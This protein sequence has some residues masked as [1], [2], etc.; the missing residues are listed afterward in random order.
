MLNVLGAFVRTIV[1]FVLIAVSVSLLVGLA[2]VP[3]HGSAAYIAGYL[4]TAL[5]LPLIFGFVGYR[6]MRRGISS[7]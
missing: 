6:M 7:H 5:L 4:T 3:V 2:W 1:G